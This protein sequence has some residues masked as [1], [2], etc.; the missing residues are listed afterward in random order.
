MLALL[1][2]LAAERRIE[3]MVR[4]WY[5]E[6]RARWLLSEPKAYRDLAEACRGNDLRDIYR[7]FTLWRVRLADA[8]AAI[9]LAE[10]LEEALFASAPWSRERS[11]ALLR[12]VAAIRWQVHRR[13]ASAG[14]PPLN[15]VSTRG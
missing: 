2:L 3:P 8:R 1:V 12:D 14:L 11:R 6:R 5:A 13:P 9:L 7:A 10:A 15:P 4:S